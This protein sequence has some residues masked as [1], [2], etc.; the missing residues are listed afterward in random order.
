MI[1]MINQ[2]MLQAQL[3]QTVAGG[4]VAGA[5][6]LIAASGA[7]TVLPA[8]SSGG[9][10]KGKGATELCSVHNKKRGVRYLTDDGA[11]GMKCA[12]GFECQAGAGE[13]VRFSSAL[14]TTRNV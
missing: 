14:C 5:N 13:G 12:P 4:T 1:A 10:D 9:K 2:M 11:G 8:W 7:V 3:Q 6:T